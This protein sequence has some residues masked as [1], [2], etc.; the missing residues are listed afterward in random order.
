MSSPRPT[1]STAQTPANGHE[2]N[3]QFAKG[4]QGGPGNPFARQVAKLRKVIR[5][6][7]SYAAT[8]RI[9]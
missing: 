2:A 9:V 4:N 8:G 7:T 5:R 3:G 1:E 6:G